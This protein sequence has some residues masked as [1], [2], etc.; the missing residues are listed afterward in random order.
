MKM[1]DLLQSLD[2]IIEDI[3]VRSPVKLLILRSKVRLLI[4]VEEAER[5][6]ARG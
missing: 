5:R 3:G 4:E 6:A 1:T 2:D